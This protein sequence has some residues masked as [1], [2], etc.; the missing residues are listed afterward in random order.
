MRWNDDL[1]VLAMRITN[2]CNDQASTQCV[3]TPHFLHV[4]RNSAIVKY[5]RLVG[6][7]KLWRDVVDTK[8]ITYLFSADESFVSKYPENPTESQSQVANII[9]QENTQIGCG[10]LVRKINTE[11]VHYVTCLY[12]QTPKPGERI[13]EINMQKNAE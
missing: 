3:N 10:I 11:F 12:K 8:W 13:F 6:M 1:A 4:A 2:F 5:N 7:K 9:L